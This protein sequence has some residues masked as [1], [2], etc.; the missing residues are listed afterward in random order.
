MSWL[1]LV[2]ASYAS[3][4]SFVHR[5]FIFA[6]GD[7]VPGGHL[8]FIFGD[9][10]IYLGLVHLRSLLDRQFFKTIVSCD[11][12]RWYDLAADVRSL[13]GWFDYGSMESWN[14]FF[15]ACH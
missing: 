8:N 13:V 3:V 1:L 14:Q 5:L 11:D 4:R 10:V 6:G 2:H 7:A 15:S 9:L 12:R